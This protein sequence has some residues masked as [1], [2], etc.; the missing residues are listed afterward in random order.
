M[1]LSELGSYTQAATA[2]RAHSKRVDVIGTTSSNDLRAHGLV[3]PF[4]SPGV[5][6]NANL[7]VPQHGTNKYLAGTAN[8]VILLSLIVLLF[9]SLLSTGWAA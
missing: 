1:H 8:V 5:K 9:E 3:E 2:T 4:L 7:G 6:A